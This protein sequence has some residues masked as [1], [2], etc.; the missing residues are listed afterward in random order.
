MSKAVGKYQFDE[1]LASQ[2]TIQNV[3]CLQLTNVQDTKM[4]TICSYATDANRALFVA[5]PQGGA[6]VAVKQTLRHEAGQL[7][8]KATTGHMHLSDAFVV[9]A[10]R[11][12]WT[13]S[14]ATMVADKL[15]LLSLIHI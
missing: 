11:T 8:W 1:L 6:T 7:A 14:T 4:L 10:K 9:H 15:Q 12:E 3:H 13:S 2:A 5:C